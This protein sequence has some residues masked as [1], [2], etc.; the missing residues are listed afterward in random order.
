MGDSD[1][2]YSGD[3]DATFGSTDV[4]VPEFASATIP[5]QAAALFGEFGK[6]IEQRKAEAMANAEAQYQLYQ[7]YT[8]QANQSYNPSIGEGLAAGLVAAIPALIGGAFMGKEGLA[9]GG[10]AGALAG[11]S[12]TKQLEDTHGKQIANALSMAK[13]AAVQRAAYQKVYDDLSMMPINASKDAA[14][15]MMGPKPVNQWTLAQAAGRE[16]EALNAW[17]GA[18]NRQGQGGGGEKKDQWTEGALTAYS[19]DPETK[20]MFN[21]P[22]DMPPEEI[23]E[24]IKTKFTPDSFKQTRLDLAGAGA[25]QKLEGDIAG[26]ETRNVIGKHYLQLI[27]EMEPGKGKQWTSLQGDYQFTPGD[28]AEL[29]KFAGEKRQQVASSAK[30]KQQKIADESRILEKKYKLEKLASE[31]SAPG[32]VVVPRQDASG[33]YIPPNPKNTGLAI[34]AGQA[35]HKIEGIAEELAHSVKT[36]GWTIGGRTGTHQARLLSML[37][38]TIRIYKA[39]GANF[40]DSEQLLN[41]SIIGNSPVQDI[42]TK[43]LLASF[44][45]DLRGSRSVGVIQDFL[46]AVRYDTQVQAYSLGFAIPVSRA[47]R[48]GDRKGERIASV[49]VLGDGRSVLTLSRADGISDDVIKKIMIEGTAGLPSEFKGP[50]GQVLADYDALI[51]D[52]RGQ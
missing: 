36:N 39:Q 28:I 25:N 10:A 21:F 41:K 31:S 26:Q 40:T 44:R 22:K 43:A 18:Q 13:E 52:I 42:D 7:D 30:I 27:E 15:K 20:K 45:A 8:Q 11:V 16:G 34:L 1:Y 50:Y 48:K 9:A 32:I 35:S 47:I 29:R 17:I 37:V 33:R 46:N 38:D 3:D 49:G 24:Y 4:G 51:A 14:L 23:K 5:P 12:Y 19:L 6:A 2:N